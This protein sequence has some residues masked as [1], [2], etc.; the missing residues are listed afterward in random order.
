[1]RRTEEKNQQLAE[2]V[3]Q[4]QN[5]GSR[6]YEMLAIEAQELNK[7]LND[8]NTREMLLTNSIQKLETENVNLRN[9][10]IN[11]QTKERDYNRQILLLNQQNNNL[12]Q[13]MESTQKMRIRLR[14]DIIGVID[15]NDQVAPN[16]YRR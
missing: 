1:M 14:N 6:E 4:L 2:Q 10:I 16:N 3:E 13:Q 7:Q 9:E 12:S 11:Y 15:Q 8:I 5:K